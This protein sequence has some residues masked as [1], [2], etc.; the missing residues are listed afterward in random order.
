ML[1]IS[2]KVSLTKKLQNLKLYIQIELERTIFLTFICFT[3]LT[4]ISVVGFF[5]FKYNTK[6][7]HI[8][9]EK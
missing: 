3:I 7:S 9:C 1:R 2:L 8:K 6:F 4:E 5:K